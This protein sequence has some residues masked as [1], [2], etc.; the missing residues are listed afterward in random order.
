MR[1]E[2]ESGAFLDALAKVVPVALLAAVG[3]IAIYSVVGVPL[4]LILIGLAIALAYWEIRNG[5]VPR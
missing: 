3:A 1:T 4:G 2:M 5:H